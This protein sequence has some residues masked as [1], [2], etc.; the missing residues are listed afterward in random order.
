[1]ALLING[2]V[3][4]SGGTVTVNDGTGGFYVGLSGAGTLNMDGGNI[5][6]SQPHLV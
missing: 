4:I 2:I 3:T 5:T 6:V 1:M